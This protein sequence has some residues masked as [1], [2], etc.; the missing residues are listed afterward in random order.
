MLNEATTKME[1]RPKSLSLETLN[2]LYPQYLTP[3]DKDA[4]KAIEEIE[5]EIQEEAEDYQL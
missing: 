4:L 3:E 5:Q 1:T 2:N